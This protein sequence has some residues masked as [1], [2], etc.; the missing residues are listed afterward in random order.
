MYRY[1]LHLHTSETSKCGHV[2]AAEQVK[3]YHELGYTGICVT[4][5]LHNAQIAWFDVAHDWNAIIDRYLVGYRAAKAAG[6]AL[7]MDV[8]FGVELRFPENDSDYLIYGIDEQWLYE[9]PWI[10]DM[11]HQTFFDRFK[12]EVLIIHAHPY[13]KNDIVYYD[14]VHGPQRSCAAACKGSPASVPHGRFRCA[15]DRRRG[16]RGDPHGGAHPRFVSAQGRH[17]VGQI[18]QLVPGIRCNFKGRRGN[19]T[20]LT[21]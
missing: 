15:S 2:P 12:D 8:I 17:H 18:P 16:T 9:H 6:E 20:C 3:T 19:R 5:H 4:D 1:E 14:C 21:P 11:N 13:R 7:G 10:T